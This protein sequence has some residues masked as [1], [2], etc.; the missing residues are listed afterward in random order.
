MSKKVTVKPTHTK[1]C[2]GKPSKKPSERPTNP[3][4]SNLST[5]KPREGLRITGKF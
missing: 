1:L 3:P 5:A 4:T 2:L